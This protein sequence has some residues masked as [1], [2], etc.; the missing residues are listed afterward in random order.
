MY[1][2]ILLQLIL[3]NLWLASSAAIY[4]VKDFGALNDGK[5][6]TTIYIQ[7]AI[8]QCSYE[9]GGVVYVPKGNYLVG[10]IN[11]K[12][13]VEFRFETGATLVATTDLSQYQKDNNGLAGVFYT[14]N[15][16]N[17]SI[18]GNGKIF[19]QGM[20]FMYADSAKVISGD[21]LN[22]VRQKNDF[23][24]VSAGLG[25]GPVYP[26]DRFQQ[27]IIFSNCY[28]VTLSDFECVDAPY[29]TFLIVH[30]DRVKV[31][32]LSIN[33][34]LLIPNSDGLDIISS[35][36]VNV[37]DCI[38]IC[39]DDAIVLAGYAHHFG[40]PGFKDI[41]KPSKNINISNCV[42]QSR[43]SGIRIGGWDQNHMSNYNFNNITIFDSNCGINI[44]VRDSGSVQNMNFS[45]INIETRL[46]TGDWWGQGEPIKISAMRGVP[47]NP[48]GIVKNINF[49]NIT[50]VAENSILMYASDE[51]KLENITFNN[52]DFILRKSALEKTS[53][54]NFDLRPNTVSGKEIYKSNIP[55]IYIEN[56]QNVYF[57]QGN[58]DWDATD[59]SYYTHAI[60]AIKVN[61]M[62]LNNMTAVS[63]PSNP[64]LP[65]ISLT[66]CTQ[67]SNNI[68][69][70]K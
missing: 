68:L 63:S 39:G 47:D 22:Y 36:N 58:I 55:V 41:R 64:K 13:D 4:N 40:D 53:G 26:K 15:A 69:K 70:R 11:L 67:V 6:L 7:K 3:I 19:G 60:E 28:N 38:I 65:A 5:T 43:S 62:K 37:S 46:H 33:N 49:S 12:S 8:D 27:M 16:K 25:D 61:N 14:E 20:E 35:S 32:G 54:G 21:V 59:A 24:K 30:C 1:K 44:T 34:N 17:V 51:T 10:T 23:R 29:W 2:R 56:A 50:C 18:T 57:N 66:N 42:L 48:V 31:S 9:G 45:N 52:F